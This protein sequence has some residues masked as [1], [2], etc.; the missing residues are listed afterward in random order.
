[1][2]LTGALSQ[3]ILDDSSRARRILGWQDSDA[4]TAIRASVDW[5]L[6]HPPT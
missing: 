1:M 3:H 6:D 2:A 5:H 4:D